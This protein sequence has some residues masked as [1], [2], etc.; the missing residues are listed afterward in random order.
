MK[1]LFSQG[2]ALT[3]RLVVFVLISLILMTVDHRQQ[4]LETLRSKLSIIAYPMQWLVDLPTTASEWIEETLVSRRTLADENTRLKTQNLLL[5]AQRQKLDALEAENQRLRSLLDSSF[6]IS[7]RVLIAELLSV[8]L[9]PYRHQILLNKGSNDGVYAG[10]ALIDAQGIMGQIIHI[11]PFSASAM[12][13]TDPA[14]AIPVQVNRNGLRTIA[15][16][17]GNLDRLNLPHLPNN[18]DIKIG[19]LLVSS[20]LGGRF[21]PGYPVARITRIKQHPGQ[22]FAEVSALPL[23]RLNRSREVLLVWQ[24]DK[25]AEDIQP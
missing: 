17:T 13:I 19:D 14:H 18:A 6:K 4:H 25:P 16:G 7:D 2:P 15:L 21:P 8:D 12:L 3:T 1:L 20:G 5:Q 10:Q 22:A 9:D 11:G 23:A 24:Q